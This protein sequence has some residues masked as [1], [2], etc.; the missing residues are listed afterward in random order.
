ML[1]RFDCP[2]VPT[3]GTLREDLEALAQLWCLVL[4][5]VAATRSPGLLP[6][7]SPDGELTRAN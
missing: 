5:A 4:G 7:G 2:S 3:T 1:A 6:G